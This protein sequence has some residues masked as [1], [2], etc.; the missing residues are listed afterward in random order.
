MVPTGIIG[1]GRILGNGGLLPRIEIHFAKPVQTSASEDGTNKKTLEEIGL[2]VRISI[3]NI[4]ALQ[5][6]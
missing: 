3:E 4:L 1:T 2:M 5:K 6:V